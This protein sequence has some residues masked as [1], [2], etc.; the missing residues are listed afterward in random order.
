MWLLRRSYVGFSTKQK[1]ITKENEIY[2][3]ILR[4]QAQDEG[5]EDVFITKEQ[6]K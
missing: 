1:R 6:V 5:E 3:N 2:K 4:L